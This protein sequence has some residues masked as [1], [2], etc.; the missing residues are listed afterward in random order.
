[1]EPSF[2]SSFFSQQQRQPSSHNRPS[3]HKMQHFKNH[4]RVQYHHEDLQF[5]HMQHLNSYDEQHQYNFNEQHQQV[6]RSYDEPDNARGRSRQQQPPSAHN[7]AQNINRQSSNSHSNSN[8]P[9]RKG[10]PQSPE[11]KRLVQQNNQYQQQS[12]KSR[13]YSS[14]SHQSQTASPNSKI[15]TNY[16][17]SSSPA[18]T[19]APLSTLSTLSTILQTTK[20]YHTSS[21]STYRTCHK[22]HRDAKDRTAKALASLSAAQA[23][24]EHARTAEEYA[25]QELESALIEKKKG[26]EYNNTV[27]RSVRKSGASLKGRRVKLVGLTQNTSW[28]GRSGTIIKLVLEGEDVGRWKIRLDKI[29]RGGDPEG[30]DGRDSLNGEIGSGRNGKDTTQQDNNASS[31]QHVVAKANNLQLIQEEDEMDPMGLVGITRTRSGSTSVRSRSKS[32]SSRGDVSRSSRDPSSTKYNEM[33]AELY[34]QVV[35]PDEKEWSRENVNGYQCN[36]DYNTQHEDDDHNYLPSGY[37]QSCNQQQQPKLISPPQLTPQ[38]PSTA[39]MNLSSAFSQMLLSPVSFDAVSFTQDSIA[40]QSRRNRQKN[41]SDTSIAG[42]F[43]DEVTSLQQ[44]FPKNPNY[45]F[46]GASYDD[47]AG[48]IVIGFEEEDEEDCHIGDVS[49]RQPYPLEVYSTDLPSLVIL[50]AV[51]DELGDT[52]TPHCIGVKNAGVPHVNGVYLLAKNSDPPQSQPLY[53]RDGPPTLL[54]DDRYYDMCI[55]RIDCPDSSDHVIWFLARVDVDP[56]CLDVKFSDCYYYCRLM[57]LDGEG[58]DG[59]GNSCPPLRGW[60]IPKEPPGLKVAPSASFSLESHP[61]EVIREMK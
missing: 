18:A 12:I 51:E 47:R 53:F 10:N 15:N 26:E 6:Q 37:H 39:G 19:L 7:A 55:L 42:S 24:L 60:N 3:Q 59:V 13:S 52:Y 33:H 48:G 25:L 40:S 58:V 23:E 35:T 45:D 38:R 31:Y 9:R 30:A 34:N 56:S 28:N 44:S 11:D 57:R 54:E 20:S 5:Q 50:P 49:N 1:M 16:P 32:R 8:T 22:L 14:S 29:V 36:G 2:S 4:Q 21:I 17:T 61:E 46:S 41:I 27:E 43:F